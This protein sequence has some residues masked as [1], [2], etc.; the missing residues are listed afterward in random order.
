MSAARRLSA[1]KTAIWDVDGTLI[2]S[3]ASI[4][5]AACEA[6]EAIGVAPPSYDQ[7]R[8][9]V[10]VSLF[11]ALA[12][13]R[14]DL[15]HETIAAYTREYQNAFLRFHADPGFH[16]SLYL[17]A[18]ETLRALKSDGWRLG[19]ATGQ[20]R[21]GVN[22]NLTTYGWSDIFDVT[23]CADDAPSKPHP[24]MVHKNL[25]HLGA[26][27]HH[28]VMIG[29]TTHDMKMARA[30]GVTAIGVSWGFHT[31]A[32]L[33]AAGAQHIVHNFAELRIVLDAFT[34]GLNA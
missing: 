25:E 15:D 28:A 33:D 16:D 13:M 21:R 8:A 10:G 20:S 34:P 5:R 7:V 22:R 12:M 29:D 32:E 1:Q 2:D 30:A 9:I 18:N 27:A 19:M 3:R 4:H 26:L 11:D 6:A 17:G 24:Q 23:F 14:P 31:V